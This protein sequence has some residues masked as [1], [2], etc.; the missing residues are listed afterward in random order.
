MYSTESVLIAFALTL[1]AGLSTGLGGAIS[2]FMKKPKMV[3]LSFFLG[4]SA[5]VMTYVSFMDLLPSAIKVVGETTG[6]IAFFLGIA[7]IAVIDMAIPQAKNPHG[8]DGGIEC[9]PDQKRHHKALMRTGLIT[10][11]S[12]GIHNFPEGLAAFTASLGD[13]HG[14]VVPLAIA[15]HNIPEGICVSVPIFCATGNKK[16]AFV[17]SLLSG[18]AEPVGAIAAYLILLP[19]LSPWLISVLLAFVAG[20]MVYISVDEL[21]PMAHKYG[22]SHAVISGVVA[23]MLIMAVSIV[24]L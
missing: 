11:L 3:Y 7:F 4:V 15:I 5:G 18:L 8:H 14:I 1:L 13:P 2:F 23:G 24:L 22:H 9:T 6:I 20:I 16:K 10:A 12:I 17:Y 21:L 19:F